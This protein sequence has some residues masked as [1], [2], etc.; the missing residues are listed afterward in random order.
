M[1]T[2]APKILHDLTDVLRLRNGQSLTVRFVEPEDI[3][4]L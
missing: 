2:I 4:P 3:G 1:P